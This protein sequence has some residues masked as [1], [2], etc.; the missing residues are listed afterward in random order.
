[1]VIFSSQQAISSGTVPGFVDV[2]K[3]FGGQ[4]L[5]EDNILLQAKNH[6]HN[7]IFFG[8]DTWL[9]LFPNTF[10]RYDGVTSFFVSDFTEVYILHYLVFFL[11]D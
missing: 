2:I 8:D 1:M 9:R 3:N 11:K 6:G 10:Q 7:I 5:M 4:V